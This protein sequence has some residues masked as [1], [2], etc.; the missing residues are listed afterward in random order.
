[1]ANHRLNR[2]KAN[3]NAPNTQA[4]VTKP[5]ADVMKPQAD[6]SNIRSDAPRDL[7]SKVP[8]IPK[9]LKE[10]KSFKKSPKIW[11]SESDSGPDTAPV[12]IKA[13]ISTT[14]KKQFPKVPKIT[15][16]SVENQNQ[17]TKIRDKEHHNRVVMSSDCTGSERH[18]RR[19][20]NMSSS[21]KQNKNK[22]KMV[23]LRT[24]MDS[25]VYDPCH[26]GAGHQSS[27]SRTNTWGRIRKEA[28]Y[29]SKPL[30]RKIHRKT[31]H[32]GP[33][34]AQNKTKTTKR[35]TKNRLTRPTKKNITQ[36][37]PDETLRHRSNSEDDH[38][39]RNYKKRKKT[40]LK[41]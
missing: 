40:P 38:S 9:Y 30:D 7:T 29:T 11:E 19:I 35:S 37:I 41:H 15:T 1:M 39:K 20:R 4:D 36:D 23:Q 17:T 31:T 27:D 33:T 16:M 25:W 3:S 18:C 12:E 5:Q 14:A 32:S 13:S 6:E 21:I 28:L 24:S 26:R 10:H 22:N 34:V 8:K 2:I